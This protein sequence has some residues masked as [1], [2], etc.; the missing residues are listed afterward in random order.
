LGG[1]IKRNILELVYSTERNMKR[2]M[3]GAGGLESPCAIAKEL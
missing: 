3:E 1:E 2:M